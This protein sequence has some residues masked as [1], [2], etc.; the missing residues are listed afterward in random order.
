VQPRPVKGEM[1][2]VKL[3]EQFGSEDRCRAY[4]EELRWPGGVACPRC[5]LKSVS[6]LAG[7]D[8]FD[9]NACRYQFSVTSGTIFHDTHLPLWKWVLAT[10]IVCESKKGVSANQIGRTL[11]VSYKTAW[12]LCHRIREAVKT[13]EN[14]PQLAG[15]VEVD[16]TFVGGRRRH[17]GKGYVGNKTI[18]AGVVQRDG[19][20]RLQTLLNRDRPALH[21]F[22]RQHVA[23]HAEAIYTDEHPAYGDLSDENTRHEK[24]DHRH[25]EW[26]RGDVHTNS[27]ESVWSLLERSIIGSFHHVS[28]KHLDRYL[29]ELEWR[30]N[31]RQ[32]PFLFRDTLKDLLKAESLKYKDLTA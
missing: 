2:L 12:Y 5:G 22:I 32:N 6:R 27:A 24:V 21:A 4:L 30:F 28:A 14:A 26:V 11:S 16:E 15:V 13:A 1:N 18:A 17:V 3:I 23:P 20:I 9:C 7:R 10:Y 31:N 25:E 8:Q 19:M 29:D